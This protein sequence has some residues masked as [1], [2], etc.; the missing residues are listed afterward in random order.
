MTNAEIKQRTNFG[1]FLIFILLSLITVGI[2]AMW[3]QWDRLESTKLA[4]MSINE[5]LDSKA[6][7]A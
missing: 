3:W 4:A 7:A 6:E 5:K 2:Y 1:A